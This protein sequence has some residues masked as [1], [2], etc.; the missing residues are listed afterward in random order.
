MPLSPGG[1]N[2][3]INAGTIMQAHDVNE[4][5][6]VIAHE[7][8]HI[9]GGHLARRKENMAPSGNMVI[10]G[11][12]LGAA[13]ILAGAPDAGMAMLLGGQSMA[14]YSA[15]GYS[16]Q[17]ESTTDQAG[18][19]FLK[20][21]GTSGKGLLEFFHTLK[22][23]E[24]LT[25]RYRNPYL[26]S[27]P[28]HLER[29]TILEAQFRESPYWDT[30]PNPEYQYWF[31]RIQG[32]LIGY[33]ERPDITLRRYPESDK[34]LVATYARIYAYQ[35]AM[36]W[37]KALS[38]ADDLIK[39]YPG[40]PFFREIAGQILFENGKTA[41]ALVYYRK[42]NQLA[43]R[44]PLIMTSLAQTLAS[45]ETVEQDLE[46]RNILEQVVFLDPENNFAWR[47]LGIIYNRA[48]EDELTSLAM[49]EMFL[50]QGQVSEALYHATNA[51][52]NIPEG[53]PKWLRLQDI[54]YTARANREDRK[55]R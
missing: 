12:L 53:T 19:R 13:A 3:F 50:L 42:A 29:I 33:M 45:L 54:I 49:A 35:K 37:D 55:R 22:D 28:L 4:L 5:I 26:S 17:Q 46:A 36:Q 47:Q 52:D 8:G 30:P 51:I 2:V 43:P 6:G 16:R 27:H 41:E 40:D 39:I 48:G 20:A 11:V 18:A 32:K 38:A 1:Q 24:Y 23:Q 9:S 7:T 15:L 21:T 44:Q 31:K 14:Q 10:A 25:G 34:S